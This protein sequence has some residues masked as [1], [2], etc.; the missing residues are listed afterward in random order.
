MVGVGYEVDFVDGR[1]VFL[2]V[3]DL[4]IGALGEGEYLGAG[5]GLFGSL[6][7]QFKTRNPFL[8]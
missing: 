6:G 4:E 1:A 2:A 7:M 8:F 5:T 3:A